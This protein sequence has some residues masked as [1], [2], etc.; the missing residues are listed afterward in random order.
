MRLVALIVSLSFAAFSSDAPAPIASQQLAPRDSHPP[1]RVIPPARICSPREVASQV[2]RFAP[3]ESACPSNE[4]W[5]ALRLGGLRCRDLIFATIGANKGYKIAGWLSLYAPEMGIY[6]NSLSNE[7]DSLFRR[8]P[9]R[10]FEDSG[11]TCEDYREGPAPPRAP[12]EPTCDSGGSD[13]HSFTIHAFEPLPGNANIL[14]GALQSMVFLSNSTSVELNIHEVAVTGD[15]SVARIE[16]G[17]CGSGNERCGVRS[18][19]P[20]PDGGDVYSRGRFVDATTVDRWLLEHGIES[21]DVLTIDTE[22]HDPAVLRG[23]DALLARGGAAVVEFETHYMRDWNVT[24]LKDVVDRLDSFG[25][26]CYFQ[27]RFATVLRLT[28]CWHALFEIKRWAN[29]LCVLREYGGG[30][31]VHAME[32]FLPK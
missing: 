12:D 27:Q 20:G 3:A 28:G 24:L 10:W 6:P 32:G 21:L 17:W 14:R 8:F 5:G 13:D 2:A 4:W 26:D 16:F 19:A 25:Y 18:S 23:A 7:Y 11:G 15:P 29:V 31:L 30:R 22:G 9:D 1:R